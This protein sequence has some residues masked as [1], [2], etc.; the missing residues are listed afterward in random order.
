MR[1]V[2]RLILMSLLTSCLA[3][4]QT[5]G[6]ATLNGTVQ[7][8]AGGSHSVNLTWQGTQGQ[9]ITFR[10]YR[11]TT[12]GTGYV[13]VQSSITGLS[14]TDLNVNNST[15]YYYVATA[16]DS[17]TNSESAYSNQVTA[18]IPN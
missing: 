12:S 18:T 14:F 8:M 6:T 17:S 15:T 4:V 16:F 3:Q 9:Y 7:L 13:M 5:T 2:K 10:I 1:I 11:S